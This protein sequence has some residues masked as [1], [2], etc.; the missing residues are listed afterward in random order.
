MVTCIPVPTS[1]P[2]L[3][4]EQWAVPVAAITIVL[5]GCVH[6]DSTDSAEFTVSVLDSVPCLLPNYSG[7]LKLDL[8][9]EFS[10]GFLPVPQSRVSPCGRKTKFAVAWARAQSRDPR[11]YLTSMFGGPRW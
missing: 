2:L 11:A 5:S 9:S 8:G 1:D 10:C 6:V 4:R 3:R 7:Y